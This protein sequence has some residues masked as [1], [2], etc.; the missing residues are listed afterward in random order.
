MFDT[1]NILVSTDKN[2][3]DI[4][5]IHSFLTQIYW[6]KGR[7][8]EQ[9]KISIDNSICFG[10]YLNNEQIGFA[11]VVSDKVIFGYLMDV[12]VLEA[13]RGRGLSKILLEAVFT[14]EILQPV[15]KWLL[16]TRDAQGLY[17]QFDFKL[18]SNP[19]RFMEK[20]ISA[21]II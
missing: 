14:N 20:I 18:I 12:F 19:E 9:V 11:R 5:M 16:I 13:Y 3:L 2:K 8:L 1:N 15:S 7:T 17:Q 21:P 6:A 10:M 4:N